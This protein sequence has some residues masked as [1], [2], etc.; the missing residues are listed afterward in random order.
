[1]LIRFSDGKLA[2]H[3]P[4]LRGELGKPEEAVAILRQMGISERAA[5]QLVYEAMMTGTAE[6]RKAVNF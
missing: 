6:V 4:E 3:S 5:R 1:M 2:M